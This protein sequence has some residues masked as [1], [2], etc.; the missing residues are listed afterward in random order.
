[1]TIPFDL[2]PRRVVALPGGDHVLVVVRRNVDAKFNMLN[3]WDLRWEFAQLRLLI[4]RD[5]RWRVELYWG[6]N[7]DPQSTPKTKPDQFWVLE[8]RRTAQ[9]FAETVSSNLR[10]GSNVMGRGLPDG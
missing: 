3:A 10:H 5:R 6:V 7:S 1:M 9:A 4:K 8:N 2:Y